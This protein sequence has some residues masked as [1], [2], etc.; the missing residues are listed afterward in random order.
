MT[1]GDGSLGALWTEPAYRRRGLAK[2]I[3]KSHLADQAKYGIP[4]FCYVEADNAAS[5]ALWESLGWQRMPWI[6]YWMYVT[7]KTGQVI[8]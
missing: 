8:G 5:M 1:H 4:G 7:S 2:V 6:S 3:L